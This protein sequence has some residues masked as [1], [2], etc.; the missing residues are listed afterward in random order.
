MRIETDSIGKQ[1]V[2]DSAYYGIHTV[3][4]IANFPVTKTTVNPLLL[5][6]K[7]VLLVKLN[8]TLSSKRVK[9]F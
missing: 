3:R 8:I 5:I 7:L 9:K 1:G 2:K 4:A 6:T